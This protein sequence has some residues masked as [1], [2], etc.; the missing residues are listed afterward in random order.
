[1]VSLVVVLPHGGHGRG[2]S[3]LELL[4]PNLRALVERFVVNERDRGRPTDLFG[5]GDGGRF[6]AA[7]YVGRDFAGRVDVGFG[8]PVSAS[9]VGGKFDA[10]LGFFEFFQGPSLRARELRARVRSGELSDRV[11][12]CW[13]HPRACHAWMLCGWANGAASEVALFADRLRT[14]STQ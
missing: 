4:T 6:D 10:L 12:S 1:M 7:V 11:L 8:N 14:L 13:C 2:V 3:D 9:G 5:G